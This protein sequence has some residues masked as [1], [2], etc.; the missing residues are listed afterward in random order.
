MSSVSSFD[1]QT[2]FVSPIRPAQGLMAQAISSNPNTPRNGNVASNQQKQLNRRST[3]S[4]SNHP[5]NTQTVTLTSLNPLQKNI[6]AAART[7]SYKSGRTFSLNSPSITAANIYSGEQRRLSMDIIDEDYYQR[8]SSSP[9]SFNF[10]SEPITSTQQ[11]RR[12]SAYKDVSTDDGDFFK[13]NMDEAFNENEKLQKLKPF[14]VFREMLTSIDRDGRFF[15]EN[16]RMAVSEMH[17]TFFRLIVTKYKQIDSGLHE[18]KT[19]LYDC[20]LSCVWILL[21]NNINVIRLFI[22]SEKGILAYDIYHIVSRTVVDFASEFIALVSHQK[23]VKAENYLESTVIFLGQHSAI[24]DVLDFFQDNQNIEGNEKW[25]FL[26]DHNE[27]LKNK[28]IEQTSSEATESSLGLAWQLSII[29]LSHPHSDQV[30]FE[31]LSVMRFLLRVTAHNI[32][33]GNRDRLVILLKLI[34][35]RCTIAS[36]KIRTRAVSLLYQMAKINYLLTNN[37]FRIK[38][39]FMLV[40]AR[41]IR[42]AISGDKN[43]LMRKKQQEILNEKGKDYSQDKEKDIDKEKEKKQI[44]K[45]LLAA[46]SNDKDVKT[47]VNANKKDFEQTNIGLYNELEQDE[48]LEIE[49]LLPQEE[50]GI[51]LTLNLLQQFAEKDPDNPKQNKNLEQQSSSQSSLSQSTQSNYSKTSP[52]SSQQKDLTIKQSSLQTQSNIKQPPNESLS[53]LQYKFDH[54]F[55]VLN[56]GILGDQDPERK[57]ELAYNVSRNYID[58]PELRVEKLELLNIIHK[59]QK[60]P[61]EL[62]MTQV[63]KCA[64]ILD[65]LTAILRQQS[66]LESVPYPQYLPIRSDYQRIGKDGIQISTINPIN[67]YLKKLDRA[68]QSAQEVVNSAQQSQI[69]EENVQQLNKMIKDLKDLQHQELESMRNAS[70]KFYGSQGCAWDNAIKEILFKLELYDSDNLNKFVGDG[71]VAESIYTSN[72]FT[73]QSATL[74]LKKACQFL[75]NA[76]M[77]EHALKL[78]NV[79]SGF[80]KAQDMNHELE[81]LH[82]NIIAKCLC[83]IREIEI[84]TRVRSTF[85]RIYL[86]GSAFGEENNKMY[87]IK[88]YDYLQLSEMKFKLIEKYKQR[89]NIE[90]EVIY[91]EKKPKMEE[92]IYEEKKQKTEEEIYEEKKQK[93]EEEIY[94][95]KKQKIKDSK[96]KI[97]KQKMNAS[98]IKEKNMNIKSQDKLEDK[99]IIILNSV[100]PYFSDEELSVRI[101][102]FDRLMNVQKFYFD[103]IFLKDHQISKPQMKDNWLLRTIFLAKQ[104]LPFLTKR[105]QVDVERI[106]ELE[107]SPAISCVFDLR[108]KTRDILAAAATNPLN[109]KTLKRL[110]QGAIAAHVSG[111]PLVIF[112]TFFK[113][114]ELKVDEDM[115]L[116]SAFNDFFFVCDNILKQLKEQKDALALLEALIPEFEALLLKVQPEFESIPFFQMRNSEQNF[117]R[118]HALLEGE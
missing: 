101:K 78:A 16:I 38:S 49:P 74:E 42:G 72:V 13:I 29:I 51:K 26:R 22:A 12:N 86:R 115:Q 82:S 80:Y 8:E 69:K 87:I 85:Y 84:E 70:E 65:L 76:N 89:F 91:K 111:G 19:E 75:L 3:L 63:A 1:S 40:L 48:T 117:D 33:M 27:N 21:N 113:N 92:E 62:A 34:L 46:F 44:I 5:G 11:Q 102:K 36:P 35:M 50:K 32:I 83:N 105:V 54:Q 45:G 93:T 110:I 71:E 98:K 103:T 15:E 118:Q 61:D 37:I 28:F 99:P 4:E 107:F 116:R 25:L 57:A 14:A 73:V 77:Q 104:P 96:N 97:K 59:E 95:E 23:M 24:C 39:V 47:D 2:Q 17:F 10:G 64:V 6:V 7:I 81:D 60:C 114:G 52:S 9:S 66:I 108:Q 18:H 31:L 90:P 30:L 41:G 100:Q 109:L 53:I 43:E 20:L 58:L 106:Q 56:K 67:Q 79:L 112:E 55:D 88:E 94:E 68:M